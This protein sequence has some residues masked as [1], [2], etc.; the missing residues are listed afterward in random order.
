MYSTF[1]LQII[2]YDIEVFDSL[3]KEVPFLLAKRQEKVLQRRK[4]NPSYSVLALTQVIAQ[5]NQS[6]TH[7][8][9]M[10]PYHFMRL[11]Q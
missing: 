7:L 8:I 4:Q 11:Y 1:A 10:K 6:R 5:V 9:L 3:G 2:Q